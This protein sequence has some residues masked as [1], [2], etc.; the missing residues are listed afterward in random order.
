M[1]STILYYPEASSAA[2]TEYYS[3]VR[4]PVPSTALFVISNP[5]TTTQLTYNFDVTYSGNEN[6]LSGGISGGAIAGIVI[7][8]MAGVFCL[9][10]LCAL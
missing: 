3:T 10:W 9:V 1:N 2:R 6:N 7:G 5:G 8:V 4:F